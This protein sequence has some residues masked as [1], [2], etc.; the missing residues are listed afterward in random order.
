MVSVVEGNGLK[1]DYVSMQDISANA[2]LAV[3]A[4][5]DQLFPDHNGFDIKS[6]EKVITQDP[7]NP[8]ACEAHQP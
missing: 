2:R 1:R 8:H 3:I 7:R 6:I 5:E 4:S